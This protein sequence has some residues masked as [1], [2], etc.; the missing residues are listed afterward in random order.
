QRYEYH[1]Q[2]WRIL[3]RNHLPLYDHFAAAGARRRA[4][5]LARRTAA[6]RSETGGAS[7][8]TEEFETYRAL[9]FS[10]AYRMLGSVADAEDVVQD[11]FV[12]FAGVERDA[13]RDAK[14][15]LA[16]IVTRL[17]LDRLKSAQA[18]REEYIGPWLDR[19]STRL[20]SSHT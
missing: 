4:V 13:V 16:T 19:K 17:A 11:A 6:A 9:L 14:S 20:N 5:S 1:R 3:E 15:F 18:T 12:R 8:M 10:I 7:R 2:P